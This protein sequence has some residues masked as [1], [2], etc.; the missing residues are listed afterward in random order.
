MV[1]ADN[2]N[3]D[4]LQLIIS[5][6]AERDLFAVAHV[7]RSFLTA[8]LPRLYRNLTFHLGNGKRY[9]KVSIYIVSM[10]Q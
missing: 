7:S 3:F 5:Y 8:A 10:F 1:S 2:L 4:C 9:P 6:L